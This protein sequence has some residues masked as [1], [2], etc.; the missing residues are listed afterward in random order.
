MKKMFEIIQ[1]TPYCSNCGESDWKRN[2]EGKLYC[3]Y[4]GHPMV[5]TREL[6]KAHFKENMKK[7]IEKRR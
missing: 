7:I 5:T 4:C 2:K 1:N 3:L 6:E